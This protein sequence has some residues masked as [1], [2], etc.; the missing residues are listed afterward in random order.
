MGVKQALGDAVAYGIDLNFPR[1][2]ALDGRGAVVYVVPTQAANLLVT[3]TRQQ[4]MRLD[5][6]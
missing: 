5:Q 4:C 2:A 1:L 3:L 6:A